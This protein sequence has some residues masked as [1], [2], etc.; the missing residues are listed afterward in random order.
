MKE[1]LFCGRYDWPLLEE[2]T[3]GGFAVNFPDAWVMYAQATN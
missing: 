1:F 2:P 3:D